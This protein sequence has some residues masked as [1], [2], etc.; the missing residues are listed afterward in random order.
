MLQGKINSI[1]NR[2]W[3]NDH[4]IQLCNSKDWTGWCEEKQSINV[5]YIIKTIISNVFQISHWILWDTVHYVFYIK[6]MSLSF[7]IY[8]TCHLEHFHLLKKYQCPFTHLVCVADVI[9]LTCLSPE[10]L[11]PTTGAYFWGIGLFLVP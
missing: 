11:T 1:F 4:R 5:C 2:R 3:S 7:I 9:S 8:L 6:I 10:E